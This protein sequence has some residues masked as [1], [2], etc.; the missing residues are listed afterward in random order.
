MALLDAER[1]GHLS[2]VGAASVEFDRQHPRDVQVRVSCSGSNDCS[3]EL[4]QNAR[5][6]DSTTSTGVSGV[7]S[8]TSH[9]TGG[10]SS[11]TTSVA[12]VRLAR[13]KAPART[14]QRTRP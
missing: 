13:P 5:A 11:I 10:R 14:Q 7:N 1:P 9:G 3:G 2:L 8:G 12:Q 6:I 4:M